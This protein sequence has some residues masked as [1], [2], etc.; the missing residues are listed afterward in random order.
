MLS[1]VEKL[2]NKISQGELEENACWKLQIEEVDAQI[3]CDKCMLFPIKKIIMII[4][5]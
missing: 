3:C 4:R 1:H 5:S 2:Q